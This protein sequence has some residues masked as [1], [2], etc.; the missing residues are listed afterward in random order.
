V[1][2]SQP[3]S[4][5]RPPAVSFAQL[6]RIAAIRPFSDS[7]RVNKQFLAWNLRISQRQG[8]KLAVLAIS[9]SAVNND[10]LSGLAHRKNRSHVILRMIIIQLISAWNM[11][12][13]VMF[14][15]AGIYE[16]DCALLA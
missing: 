8:R 6:N 9:A 10:F 3:Y 5:V 2:S 1:F 14:V 11:A 12:T 15:V 13:L 16:N 4:F 7:A